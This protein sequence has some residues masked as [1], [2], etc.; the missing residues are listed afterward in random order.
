MIHHNKEST[1]YIGANVPTVMNDA[2]DMI[3]MQED[4]SKSRVI[5]ALLREAIEARQD[6]AIMAAVDRGLK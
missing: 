3:A 6:A 5:I 2:L 1:R 4:R